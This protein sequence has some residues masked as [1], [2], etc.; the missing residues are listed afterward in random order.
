MKQVWLLGGGG[1]TGRRLVQRLPA[2]CAITIT[3]RAP[4]KLGD[5]F[6]GVRVV[7]WRPADASFASVI[8]GSPAPDV[9]VNLIGAW[10]VNARTALVEATRDIVDALAPGT[11]Y[12]HCSAVSVWGSRPGEVVDEMSPIFA[13]Q[14]VAGLHFEAEVEVEKARKR[15]I[16]SVVLRLPHI[17]GPGRERTVTM[18]RH[19]RF[20]ILGDGRN[21]MHHL[22]VDDFVDVLANVALREHIPSP[23]Y[24]IVDDDDGTYGDYCDFVTA[25]TGAV[26]LP[27]MS[28]TDALNGHLENILGPH[29]K[30]R[31][32]VAEFWR[33]MTSDL[34]VDNGLMKRELGVDLRYPTFREGLPGVIDADLDFTNQRDAVMKTTYEEW[35]S[36][37]AADGRLQMTDE[38]ADYLQATADGASMNVEAFSSDA[39]RWGRVALLESSRMQNLN[40]VIFPKPDVE[41]PILGIEI[42][43]SPDG[44][45]SFA[46]FDCWGTT[47]DPFAEALDAAGDALGDARLPVEGR[48]AG[49]LSQHAVVAREK[50]RE[51]DVLRAASGLLKS[52]IDAVHAADS[53]AAEEGQAE[54]NKRCE[55]LINRPGGRDHLAALFGKEWSDTFLEKVYYPRPS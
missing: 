20:V 8:D 12:I 35:T 27:F 31:E 6:D 4:D 51:A 1:D 26:P 13:D 37:V 5:G 28:L 23:L 49:F 33:F 55:L 3:S 54:Q 41:A 18:M 46:A 19:G 17:Y 44:E 22:H 10:L 7:E 34:R 50:G 15:G 40:V 9:V 30:Q 29:F 53:R 39:V 42:A 2:D 36:G 16:D 45:L 24:A 21:R 11:R 43:F 32:V 52:Y 38:P 14:R 25:A 48:L 47:P